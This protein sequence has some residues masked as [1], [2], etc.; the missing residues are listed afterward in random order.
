MYI[1]RALCTTCALTARAHLYPQYVAKSSK[2]TVYAFLGPTK[3]IYIAVSIGMS[4]DKAIY[5]WQIV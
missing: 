3:L 1:L 5:I 2:E 4:A